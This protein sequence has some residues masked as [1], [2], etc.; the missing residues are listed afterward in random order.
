MSAAGV[1]TESGI[2]DNVILAATGVGGGVRLLAAKVLARGV[3]VETEA[4]I[5]ASAQ[6]GREGEVAAGIVKNTE[7]IPSATGK[8]AYRIPDE[9]NESVLGEVKNVKHLDYRSQLQDDVA[10]AQAKGLRFNLYVRQSTTF[11][12]PLQRLID[13]GV[14]TRVPSLGP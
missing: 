1:A 14:I 12:G 8:A 11:S 2:I 10:Y 13:A 4:G 7:R 3:A 5:A 6:L 9:L